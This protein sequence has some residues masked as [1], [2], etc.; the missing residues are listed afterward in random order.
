MLDGSPEVLRDVAVAT[1]FG[2][3]FAVTDFV[4]HNFGFMIASDTLFD[5][6]SGV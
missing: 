4:G 5:I 1:N 3:Q 6:A 2:K